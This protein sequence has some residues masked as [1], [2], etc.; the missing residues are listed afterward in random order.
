MN[1]NIFENTIYQ[2][3]AEHFGVPV[4]AIQQVGT[5]LLSESKYDG[6][7][8]IALWYIGKHTFIQLDPAYHHQLDVSGYRRVDSSRVPQK[9]VG[10]GCSWRS[11]RLVNSARYYRAIPA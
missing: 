7:K 1:K 9:R 3:W 11:M 6:D 4:E 8:I 5:I 10:Q 2:N